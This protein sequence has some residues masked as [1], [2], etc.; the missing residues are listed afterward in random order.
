[1]KKIIVIA[2]AGVNHNGN[3]KIAK[4][5]IN[6]AK[7]AKADYVKFQIY[8][9]ENLI[10]LNTKTAEYQKRNLGNK[11]SQYEMLKK[12]ELSIE[13]IKKLIKY[14][15]KKKIKFLCSVFDIKSYENL[16]KLNIFDIKIPSGEINNIPLLK[17]I[18]V[19]AK[20][21]FLSTGMATLGE[22][23][24][25]IKIFKKKIKS[26]LYVLHCHSDYPTKYSDVNLSVMSFLKK[27]FKVNVGYSDH[28]LGNI[29]GISAA[30]LGAK[31]IEKHFTL[32]KKMKG[33]DHRASLEPHQLISFIAEIRKVETILGNEIKKI[34]P[35]EKKNKK[36]VRKSIVATKLIKKGEKF[37]NSNIECKRP[38]G[39][40]NPK[41]LSKILGRKAKKEFLKDQKIYL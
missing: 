24:E 10:S 33:P 34:S 30:S 6:V 41:Y 40:L 25:A 14:S 26:N 31:V 22:I 9:T 28:T 12:Y 5:L 38:E 29:V 19:K 15:K 23:S 13:D 7:K 16:K 36:L 4:K 3:I 21:V 2:E 8:K 1:M 35:A 11:I 27:K 20:K 32:S 37:T 39:G 18:S 17:K